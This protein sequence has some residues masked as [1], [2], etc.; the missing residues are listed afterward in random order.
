[1]SAA[2]KSYEQFALHS[3]PLLQA[4]EAELRGAAEERRDNHVPQHR[5]NLVG[6]HQ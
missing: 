5:G 6:R 4:A 1:M 3:V 2:P